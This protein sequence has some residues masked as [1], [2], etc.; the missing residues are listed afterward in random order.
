[1]KDFT[2]WEIIYYFRTK[3]MQDLIVLIERINILK[4][5]IK[6]YKSYLFQ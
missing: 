5:K 3:K 6:E 1:M 2:W 4:N